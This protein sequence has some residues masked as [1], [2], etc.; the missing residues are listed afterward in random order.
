ML[1]RCL[2]IGLQIVQ[3]KEQEMGRV[4]PALQLLL[5]FGA[6][7]N[8]DSLLEHQRTPFHLI[9]LSAGDHHDLLDLLIQSSER[10]LLHVKD[11]YQCTALVYAVP[12]AN[13]N[14]LR[15]LIAKGAEVNMNNSEVLDRE[16]SIPENESSPIELAIL[17]LQDRSKNCPII[18]TEI[19]DLL[20]DSGAEMKTALIT[21]LS[22][23]RIECIKKLIMKGAPLDHGDGCYVWQ[24]SAQRGSV[25]VLKCLFNRGID[26]DITD[27]HG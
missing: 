1:D 12:N 10:T 2:M 4:A 15:T 9:C 18:M 19:F 13:I 27:Q 8:P 20:L 11:Y 5:Q 26:K 21:A 16:R 17:E 14:C 24:M 6:K 3:K 22:L 7:W 23:G 25:D